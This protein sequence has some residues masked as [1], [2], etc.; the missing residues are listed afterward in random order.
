MTDI[1]LTPAEIQARVL[2]RDQL[3]IVLDKPPGIP[4]H[5]GPKGGSSL[6][7]FFGYLKFDYK[8]TPGLAHRLDR[9]TS[10]CLALGR[11]TRALRKLGKLF[12]SGRVKK[13]YWAIVDGRPPAEEGTIDLPLAKIKLGKGWSMQ[14]SKKDAPGA[15]EAVTEYRVVKRLRKDRTWLELKPR[16]GR[17]HQLRVHLQSLGCPI[18]G[19]W[20]Y[21]PAENRPPDGAFPMLHLHARAIELPLYDDKPAIAAAAELPEHMAALID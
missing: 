19:D 3:V 10:G 18:T 20:L 11:N 12:E 4:V 8:E 2:F 9:D 16:T 15:Q 17:T 7:D 5:A 1:I 21:G 6:E 13:T 14:P